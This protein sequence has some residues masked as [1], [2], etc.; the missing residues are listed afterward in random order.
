M[1]KPQNKPT[2]TA[3]SAPVAP[4]ARA[5]SSLLPKLPDGAHD[6]AALEEAAGPADTEIQRLLLRNHN[7]QAFYERG[8]MAESENIVA[9]V[10]RFVSPS[11]RILGGL[12]ETRRH[13]PRR[14]FQRWGKTRAV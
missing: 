8:V 9:D 4:K 3:K 6:L 14:R 12:H 13:P 7:E 11:L 1:A 5:G 10:P 2:S